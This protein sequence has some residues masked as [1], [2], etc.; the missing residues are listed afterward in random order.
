M[1]P[2]QYNERTRTTGL[3]GEIF[4]N[5]DRTLTGNQT[6][7]LLTT[8]TPGAV[9]GKQDNLEPQVFSYDVDINGQ[10]LPETQTLLTPGKDYTLSD[11]SLGRIAVTV[12]NMNQQ[13]PILYRLIGQF[14]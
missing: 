6:L 3:D 12:P 14:I 13:K 5:L 2:I 4:Y 7:E 9:F 11:N 10:I 8:E 1:E